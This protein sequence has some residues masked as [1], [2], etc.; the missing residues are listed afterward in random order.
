VR[1]A[2][3]VAI[4][5]SVVAAFGCRQTQEGEWEVQRPTVGTTVDT[6]TP[7]DIRVGTDTETVRVPDVDVNPQPRNP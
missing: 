4:A 2:M 5:L 6:L 7:P 1:K 3:A